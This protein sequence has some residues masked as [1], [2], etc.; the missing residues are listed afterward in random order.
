VPFH[1]NFVFH[2]SYI[3]QCILNYW[4]EGE[5]R[6]MSPYWTIQN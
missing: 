1:P 3:E 2:F 6:H 5:K 4:N